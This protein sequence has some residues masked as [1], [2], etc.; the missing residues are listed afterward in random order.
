V[1]VWA[2]R[3]FKVRKWDKKA[4]D[5][6]LYLQLLINPFNADSEKTWTWKTVL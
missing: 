6:H 5:C 1:T 4:S 3:E 2:L